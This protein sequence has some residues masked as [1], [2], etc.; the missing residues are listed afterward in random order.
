MRSIGS[1]NLMRPNRSW[2]IW[3]TSMAAMATNQFPSISGA[4]R[5]FSCKAMIRTA[6]A[7]ASSMR[8]CMRR[9]RTRRARTSASCRRVMGQLAIRR[10]S[11]VSALTQSPLSEQASPSLCH[12]SAGSGSSGCSARY[13]SKSRAASRGRPSARNTSPRLN[14]AGGAKRDDANRV[15]MSENF[16]AASGNC[17][18][19]KART[20]SSNRASGS[21]TSTTKPSSVLAATISMGSIRISAIL[22]AHASAR[23]RGIRRWAS[24]N[25]GTDMMGL[26]P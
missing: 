26:S 19:S 25:R 12:T 1:T 11:A 14:R 6:S 18:C 13:R 10:R 17:F 5:F 20:P 22:G 15:R 21:M 23:Q 16:R 2:W 8:P 7:M 9:L 24:R 3:A 4:S